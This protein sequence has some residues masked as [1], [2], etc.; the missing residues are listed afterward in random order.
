MENKVDQLLEELHE[1][2]AKIVELHYQLSEK[3]A[4]IKKLK[5]ALIEVKEC[6][7]AFYDNE[8]PRRLHSELKN[9]S[10]VIRVI[11][12]VTFDALK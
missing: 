5:E 12:K 4:E 2:E 11:D 1:S 7:D 3:N 6:V 8:N 9:F 10:G